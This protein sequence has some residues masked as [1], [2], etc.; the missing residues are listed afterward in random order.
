MR[1]DRQVTQ[2]W[3]EVYPPSYSP[4]TDTHELVQPNVPTVTLSATA[5]GHIY[6][7][8]VPLAESG[9]HRIVLYAQD[10]QGL[11]SRPH[12]LRVDVLIAHVYLPLVVRAR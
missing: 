6:S 8:T 1:D 4:P 5:V 11:V 2:V 3:A 12:E 7:G 10:D 9:P